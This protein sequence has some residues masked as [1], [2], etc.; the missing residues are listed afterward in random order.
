VLPLRAADHTAAA[1]RQAVQ[2]ALRRALAGLG[3]GVIDPQVVE[4]LQEIT[5]EDCSHRRC[6]ARLAR[7]ADAQMLV[8]GRLHR[9]RQGWTLQLWL[10][11]SQRRDQLSVATS[12]ARCVS[13]DRQTLCRRARGLITD[14]LRKARTLE[15]TAQLAV[16]STPAG[17]VVTIDGTA[18]GATNMTFGVTPGRHVVTLQKE[19]FRLSVH[20]VEVEPG[21]RGEI[22]G[23][24]QRSEIGHRPRRAPAWLAWTL[25]ATS[26]A[27]LAPGIALWIAGRE[28]PAPDASGVEPTS[29]RNY[30]PAGVALTAV[31]A[32][33][34]VAAIV[35]FAVDA[36]SPE[37]PVALEIHRGG[38]LV[39]YGGRF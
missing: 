21:A 17:A 27:A 24:L 37:R 26:L 25:G 6:M 13:C 22:D 16:R 30:R 34:G 11:D 7:T 36:R 18:M 39:S 8:G 28:D 19:G 4:R 31:G 10:Y 23:H 35:L 2:G 38:A 9:E 20:E 5:P 15:Q 14:L 12:Q 33:L 29:V 3:L 1:E 32:A